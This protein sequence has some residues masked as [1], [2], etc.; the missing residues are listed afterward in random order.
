MAME[1]KSPKAS[2]A[3]FNIRCPCVTA[4]RCCRQC[5]RFIADNNATNEDRFNGPATILIGELRY[6]V[7]CPGCWGRLSPS[8][9][10][11]LFTKSTGWEL[12]KTHGSGSNYLFSASPKLPVAYRWHLPRFEYVAKVLADEFWQSHKCRNCGTCPVDELCLYGWQT[13]KH[14]VVESYAGT[15]ADV[16][17]VLM[18]L[19]RRKVAMNYERDADVLCC[20]DSCTIELLDKQIEPTIR[21]LEEEQC[22]EKLR[23][24]LS[25]VNKLLRSPKGLDHDAARSLQLEFKLLASS[26][27][28]CL[29]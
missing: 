18:W 1:T 15:F 13:R 26:R 10:V 9:I 21:Q 4:E 3:I 28:S 5:S 14:E 25:Q 6:D 19:A 8:L 16:S 11:D 23:P 2:T 27:D 12:I 29:T 7:L 22:L 17:K 24:L 20:S